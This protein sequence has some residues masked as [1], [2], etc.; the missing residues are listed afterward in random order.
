MRLAGKITGR[1]FG[2]CSV[3]RLQRP[4]LVTMFRKAAQPDNG[5]GRFIPRKYDR[6]MAVTFDS[7]WRAFPT[8]VPAHSRLSHP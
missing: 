1:N 5:K 2:E 8:R 7:T 3:A 6:R 4:W